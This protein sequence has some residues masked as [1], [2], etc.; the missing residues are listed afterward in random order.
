[1]AMEFLESLPRPVDDDAPR[2]FPVHYTADD[3]YTYA[4][5]DLSSD[6]VEG[7]R[8]VFQWDEHDGWKFHDANIMPFPPNSQAS[9]RAVIDSKDSIL[10]SSGPKQT[11]DV[12]SYGFDSEPS[13]S[14]DD[15]YW[16]AYGSHDMH[17]SSHDRSSLISDTV[18]TED[19]YWARYSSV[20]GTADST[21]PSPLPIHRRKPHPFDSLP[22]DPDS[23]HP[24][25]V[26]IGSEDLS[27]D[28]S[29]L[30]LVAMP[31]T[32]INSR[33]DPASP[34]TLAQL[35][36]TISPRESAPHSP[37]PSSEYE[38]QPDFLSPP[39]RSSGSD[40]S[41][42][43]SPPALGF[44]V[45]DDESPLLPKPVSLRIGVDASPD[46]KKDEEKVLHS[47]AADTDAALRQ[48]LR[49]LYALYKIQNGKGSDEE[50]LSRAFLRIAEEVVAS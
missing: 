27:D 50:V 18:G 1:M 32:N 41:M 28:T 24:L 42:T 5:A 21:R 2:N 30:P 15:D 39:E 44:V 37:R 13:E 12:N 49:G 6:G 46:L 45:D 20:H 7:P 36:A 34:Q 19:A 48:S 22:T 43:P 17:D 25:P 14:D 23:P 3:E 8:L 38:S 10:R 11:Q 31:R 35:L 47:G 9:L 26:R 29:P 4:H 40:D 16:N 33:W